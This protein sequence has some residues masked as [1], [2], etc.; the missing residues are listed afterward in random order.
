MPFGA[1]SVLLTAC[2]THAGKPPL[3]FWPFGH[4][5]VLFHGTR[6]NLSTIAV[7][8]VAFQDSH[9]YGFQL[10][11]ASALG[12]PASE[13]FLSPVPSSSPILSLLI[14]PKVLD[15]LAYPHFSSLASLEKQFEMALFLL[16]LAMGT[17]MFH[18][19]TLFHLQWRWTLS[20]TGLRCRWSLHQHY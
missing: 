2:T 7:F 6:L 17:R 16:P 3:M 11:Y 20:T 4:S 5:L 12:G 13:G 10:T 19:C 15:Y 8:C 9:F 14:S 18:H 1:T